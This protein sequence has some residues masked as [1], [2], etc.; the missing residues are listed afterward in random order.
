MCSNFGCEKELQRKDYEQHFSECPF[1][2]EKC[3][4]CYTNIT[5]REDHDCIQSLRKR[6][7]F[8]EGIMH[9]MKDQLDER[10]TKA[11]YQGNKQKIMR[12]D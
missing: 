12:I 3:E 1:K 4:K 7:E 5:Q 8:I 6:C 11:S 10:T 9:E 2:V